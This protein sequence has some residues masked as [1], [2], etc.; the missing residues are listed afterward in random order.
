MPYQSREAFLDTRIAQLEAEV[1][2]YQR[3]RG[4][5]AI[6]T[7]ERLCLGLGLAGAV[8]AAVLGVALFVW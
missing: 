1:R 4:M 5:V 8:V 2:R 7:A 6:E 3:D